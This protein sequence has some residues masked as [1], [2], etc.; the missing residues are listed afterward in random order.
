MLR[1]SISLSI[2]LACLACSVSLDDD[3]DESGSY[4][5]VTVNDTTVVRYMLMDAAFDTAPLWWGDGYLPPKV[6][7]DLLEDLWDATNPMTF[8][9]ELPMR[10]APNVQVGDTL[11]DRMSNIEYEL[12][13]TS[14]PDYSI[15]ITG[16]L[17]LV[18]EMRLDEKY[19]K[20]VVDYDHFTFN[21]SFSGSG[22]V[23]RV[24]IDGEMEYYY[25]D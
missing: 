10:Y 4:V 14:N 11:N 13:W 8:S 21:K 1:Y 15:Q 19:P 9:Y 16:G 12:Y 6:S 20:I 18:K 3:E 7:T 24:E 5:Q 22:R 23:Y 17:V 2:M 25:Y